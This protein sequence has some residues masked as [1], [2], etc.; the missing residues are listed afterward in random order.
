[1]D[2]L[3]ANTLL[4]AAQGPIHGDM[5]WIADFFGRIWEVYGQNK[6]RSA[7]SPLHC[8]KLTHQRD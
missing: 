8:T 7:N 2:T 5:E 6:R 1:M 4:R 3:S